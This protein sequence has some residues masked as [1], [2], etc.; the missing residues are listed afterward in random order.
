[1][2]LLC[3]NLLFTFFLAFTSPS[4]AF[5]EVSIQHYFSKIRDYHF[6][7]LREIFS[8][9]GRTEI[10]SFST[11]VLDEYI[12]LSYSSWMV[13]PKASTLQ[14][15]LKLEIYEMRDALGAF[16]VFSI[17]DGLSREDPP[18]RLNLPVDNHY[19]E[20]SLIFWRGN[21]FF[22]L[23]APGRE[24][25]SKQGFRALAHSLIEAIPLLNLHPMTVIHLPKERLIRESIRF[26]LGKSSFALNDYFPKG[27][28]SQIG[29][30]DEIEV[31]FAQ[32]TPSGGILFLVGYPT[33]ALAADYFVKLQNGMQSYFSRQGVYMK[34]AGVMISIF[35]G[36]ESE[37][38][39]I[40]EKVRYVPTIKW[41]YNKDLDPELLRRRATSSFFGILRRS[42]LLT[43]V[44]C[45]IT[46]GGGL[47]V[48]LIRY[49]M[50]KRF[51]KLSKRDE[52]VRLGIANL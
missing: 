52:V 39:E 40:L 32:Y 43:L 46:I 33:V 17:W 26:Y 34:R 2:R 13:R 8:T 1:M 28:V 3:R 11:Q 21:Y 7:E 25:I 19:R 29:F 14:A 18:E 41:I 38:R 49:Q 48:A 6:D 4:L 9:E 50:F 47:T 15:P 5:A 22:H 20:H 36:P 16:G 44:F 27:A 24:P 10:G 45:S 31:T 23:T 42:L 12:L 35:F 51:P 30:E 37:A